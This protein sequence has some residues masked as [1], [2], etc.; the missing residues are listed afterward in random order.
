[1]S[2]ETIEFSFIEEFPSLEEGIFSMVNISRTKLKS[3][4]TIK[5]NLNK[6]VHKQMRVSLPIDLVNW[7]RISGVYTGEGIKKIYEDKNFLVL[8]KPPRV[9]CHPL[10]YSDQNNVLSFI[11]QKYGY[12][13]LELNIDNYDRGLLYR[14]DF[15]TS[16]CLIYVKN[17]KL[18]EQLR[19]NFASCVKVKT[20]YAVVSG[21]CTLEGVNRTYLESYGPRG[22]MVRISSESRGREAQIDIEKVNYNKDR[23]LTL[24]KI[25][26]HQGHRHQ[27]RVQ[28][29]GLGYPIL[30]D[31][32]YGVNAADRMYLHCYEYQVGME[33]DVFKF[34]DENLELFFN[35]FSPN[36]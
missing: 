6:K 3:F 17:E 15:E 35:L 18:L 27:I 34:K 36:S 19:D 14:L 4:H 2:N 16:G 5:K 31:P 30:G 9:H 13:Y 25:N 22:S 11:S 32:L 23:N 12:Q 10:A 28:L 26:L 29:Q 8:S 20:Y 24:L 1:M 33:N 21:Q 7:G